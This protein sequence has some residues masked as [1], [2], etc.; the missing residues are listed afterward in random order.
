MENWVTT[1]ITILIPKQENTER[2]KHYRSI[3]CA[4]TMYITITSIISKQTHK[5]TDDRN[6]IPK[7]KKGCC[8]G[9]KGCKDQLLIAKAI[10]QE[11]KSRKKNVCTT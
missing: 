2:T 7:E 11:C 8:R 3:I 10:L 5:Y 1:G 4:S 6:L 9:S